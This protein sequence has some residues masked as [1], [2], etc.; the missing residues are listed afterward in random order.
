MSGSH[1]VP[2]TAGRTPRAASAYRSNCPRGAQAVAGF[3]RADNHADKGG[4]TREAITSCRESR[5][6]TPRFINTSVQF[7]V[8]FPRGS[9]SSAEHDARLE[10]IGSNTRLSPTEE[11]LLV[12]LRDLGKN[13]PLIY[14][15]LSATGNGLTVNLLTAN[16]GLS[17]GQVRYGLAP[18]LREGIVTMEG[19]QGDRATVY[20]IVQSVS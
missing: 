17:T 16:T 1:K 4:G 11:D 18:L 8:L 14:Q 15:A 10:D 9:R 13:V 2:R 5:V 7:T 12:N 3:R 6:A 19:G 20:R